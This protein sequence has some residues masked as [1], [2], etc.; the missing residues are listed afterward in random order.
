MFFGKK[1]EKEITYPSEMTYPEL[2]SR[3]VKVETRADDMEQ[4]ISAFREEI[5]QFWENQTQQDNKLSEFILKVEE[6]EKQRAEA[7]SNLRKETARIEKNRQDL[8]ET[9]EAVETAKEKI[10]ELQGKVDSS[11][12]E[13][14][15]RV[16]NIENNLLDIRLAIEEINKAL[17]PK[18]EELTPQQKKTY[19]LAK[20]GLP[21]HKIGQELGISQSAVCSCLR[22]IKRKGWEL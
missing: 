19:D 3:Q 6:S 9:R 5:Q 20:Q 16:D 18:Q 14:T 13:M 12:E 2:S 10:E 17:K 21:Q 4:Q 1:K 15:G 8:S 11:A 7:F 22:A